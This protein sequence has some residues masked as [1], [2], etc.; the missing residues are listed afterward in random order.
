MGFDHVLKTEVRVVELTK[1]L[2]EALAWQPRTFTNT[3]ACMISS[4]PLH[5]ATFGV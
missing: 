2:S 5:P 1:R 4:L 3:Q